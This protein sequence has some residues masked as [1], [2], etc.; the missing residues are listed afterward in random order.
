MLHREAKTQRATYVGEPAAADANMPTRS[1]V[2]LN[3]GLDDQTVAH[4]IR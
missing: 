3:E 2:E 1:K 4:E